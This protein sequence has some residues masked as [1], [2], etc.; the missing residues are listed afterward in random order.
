[1]TELSILTILDPELFNPSPTN[2]IDLNFWYRLQL[3]SED[4][5]PRLG[6]SSLAALYTIMSSEPR[7]EGLPKAEFWALLGPLASRVFSQQ[8]GRSTAALCPHAFEYYSPVLGD[9]SNPALLAAD[10]AEATDFHALVIA[11]DPRCWSFDG[12][13]ACELCELAQPFL[14]GEP[15]G[16]D[17]QAW[18]EAFQVFRGDDLDGLK[19]YAGKMFPKVIFHETAWNNLA[20]LSQEP[21]EIVLGL[22]RHLGGLNDCGAEI[23]TRTPTADGRKAELGG[24]GI[25][26]SME[27]PRIHSDRKA[28]KARR[29]IFGEESVLCEWH[30]KLL[31]NRDRIYFDVRGEQIYVGAIVKHL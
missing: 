3:W 18:R 16:D 15:K 13:S 8:G 7:V 19:K 1:M 5:R 27:S 25:R 14:L 4:P 22:I 21:E 6:P 23:W 2:M 28:M 31:P 11:T 24:L 12:V 29:F 26:A 9:S 10:I 20:S 30:T 17:S